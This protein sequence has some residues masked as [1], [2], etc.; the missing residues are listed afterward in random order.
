MPRALHRRPFGLSLLTLLALA[1]GWLLCGCSTQTGGA[2]PSSSP[3]S[4]SGANGVV[5]LALPSPAS[6]P[7]PRLLQRFDPQLSIQTIAG[8][9]GEQSAATL[10]LRSADL[11]ETCTNAGVARLAADALI[12]PI[13]TS[14]IAQWDQV[15]PVL[16]TLPGVVVDGKV[17]MVPLVAD[18]TG[19]I[20]D[21][22][23]V[24]APPRAFRDLF[25]PRYRGRLA[26]A[27][28]SA[29]A[30]A[31]A[32]LNLGFADPG[33]LTAAEVERVAVYL[34]HYRKQF[35]SFW[36]DPA[37]LARAFKDGHVTVAVGDY[38]TFVDLRDR[39]APVAF[40]LASEGQPVRACGLAIPTHARDSDGAYAIINA[41]LQPA[42]QGRLAEATHRQAA[43]TDAAGATAVTAAGLPGD[44]LAHLARSVPL[45]SELDHP[46][47]IQT[48]YEV[49]MRRG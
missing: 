8:A 46:E 22:G 13:D 45:L 14:R 6:L 38:A 35:R 27:D 25:A 2:R 43:V 36:L 49:K 23:R 1:A 7:I 12:R 19:I 33:R 31:V 20:Y 42:A 15:Y 34:K 47:W 37:N 10:A 39:G 9:G 41:L 30:T 4:G 32:A 40:A 5:L 18:I 29:L 24:P 11:V 26:F 48:W 28:D 21:P 17:Y 3:K 16:R 44:P